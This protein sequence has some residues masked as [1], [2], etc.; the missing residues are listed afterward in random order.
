MALESG[1]SLKQEDAI[2]LAKAHLD[3]LEGNSAKVKLAEPL[4]YIPRALNGVLK[5]K[6]DVGPEERKFLGEIVE[7]AE[8]IR[9]TLERTSRLVS[10]AKS[11]EAVS[12]SLLRRGLATEGRANPNQVELQLK[13]VDN[14]GIYVEPQIAHAV[15]KLHLGEV[16]K[17]TNSLLLKGLGNADTD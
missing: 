2:N 11:D 4:G 9:G 15:N 6:R 1:G 5:Q 13:T 3:D 17:E 12:T 14:S 16:V 7:P 10:A 8:K